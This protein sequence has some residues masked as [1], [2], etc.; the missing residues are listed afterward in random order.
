MSSAN[1]LSLMALLLLLSCSASQFGYQDCTENSECRDAFGWGHV[2]DQEL[3]LCGPATA[4]IRCMETWPPNLYKRQSELQDAILIGIQFDRSDFEREMNAARLAVMQVMDNEGLSGIDYALVECTN[5]ENSKYDSLSQD[6]ANIRVS[7]YLADEIGVAAI[8]GPATSDRVDAAYLAVQKYGTLLMSPTATSPALTDLDGL[9]STDADPGLLWRTAPPDDLQGAVLAEYISSEG[10]SGDDKPAIK[11]IDLIFEEGPYGTALAFV[12]SEEFKAR[13]GTTKLRGYGDQSGRDE[14]ILR[15]A[16][17]SNSGVLFISATKD[18]T[19][20]FL[21]GVVSMEGLPSWVFLA[22]GAKDPDIFEAVSGL[23]ASDLERIRGTAPAPDLG[24]IY[25]RF[26][27]AYASHFGDDA[28]DSPYTPYAYDAA[29]LVLY[30]TAWSYLNEGR[31]WG[32]GMGRGLRRLS[33]G[34]PVHVDPTTWTSVIA[35]FEEGKSINVEGAS[36]HLDYDDETGETSA[37]IEVWTVE[38]DD[39][40]VSFDRLNLY[41][42]SDL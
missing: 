29:W 28:G 1:P 6:E 15:A 17:S 27:D 30:G 21:Q 35:H 22:D 23:D 40:S 9:E 34:D 3:G 18:D 10:G 36:G 20:V 12:F 39:S 16:D 2:C 7:E 5:E 19:T 37:P 42:P 31:V 4:D 32:E 33:R 26:A 38:K 14:Q 25:E 13:G 41:D 8:I 11:T 24:L